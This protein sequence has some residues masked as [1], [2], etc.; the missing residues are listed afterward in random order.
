MT[1]S[2]GLPGRCQRSNGR[3]NPTE[4]RSTFTPQATAMR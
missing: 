4:N 1:N 3:P 2:V